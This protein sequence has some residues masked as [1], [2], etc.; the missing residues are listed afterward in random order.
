MQAGDVRVP[1]SGVCRLPRGR[2]WGAMR[3]QT[4]AEGPQVIIQYK[5]ILR[6]GSEHAISVDVERAVRPAAAV[7]ADAPAWTQLGFRQCHNCPLNTQTHTHC[8]PALDLAPVI[9]AFAKIISYAEAQVVVETPERVSGKD[10]QVQQAL[11]SLVAL[12]MATSGC[13]ILGRMRGLARTHLPF[14]TID[15][16]LFRIAGAYL[17][18]QLIE[19][20][21]G[22]EPDWALQK[23]REHY[24][25]LEILNHAFTK[26]INAAAVEDATLNAVSALGVLSMGIGFTLDDQLNELERLTIL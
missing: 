14:S 12:I 21:R 6:D 1:R 16:T 9:G 19:Q 5:F 18:K 23:L 2:G 15:E 11:S 4:I 17:I 25:E 8:P 3:L 24:V 26:R 22:S 7:P 13:P 10:C 20:R